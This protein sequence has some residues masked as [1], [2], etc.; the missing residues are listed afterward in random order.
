MSWNPL[1]LIIGAVQENRQVKEEKFH[2]APLSS[3]RRKCKQDAK[4]NDDIELQ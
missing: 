4:P 1:L 3:C 2:G